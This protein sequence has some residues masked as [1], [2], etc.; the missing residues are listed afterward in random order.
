MTYSDFE[1]QTTF[2][3]KRKWPPG[4]HKKNAKPHKL[5]GRNFVYELVEDTDVK[6]H[7]PM[8]IIL[9]SYVEGLGAKGDIVEVKPNFAYNK[10]ILPKLG[11]YKTPEN[12]EKFASKKEAKDEI[13]HSSP[14]APKVL[15]S[16]LM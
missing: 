10:L 8:E 3:L 12:I 9:T 2:V 6:K 16:I 7:E 5:R 11:V 15:S 1:F 13:E 14:F 4:L